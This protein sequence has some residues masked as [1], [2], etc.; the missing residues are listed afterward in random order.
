VKATRGVSVITRAGVVVGVVLL[1]ALGGAAVSGAKPHRQV[2]DSR[3]AA[4]GNEYKSF[5]ALPSLPHWVW[6]IPYGCVFIRDRAPTPDCQH[7]DVRNGCAPPP[8]V[9]VRY[10]GHTYV[11]HLTLKGVP[12]KAKGLWTAGG[13]RRFIVAHDGVPPK[14]RQRLFI[15]FSGTEFDGLL[16]SG[17]SKGLPDLGPEL[18]WRIA[19]NIDKKNGLCCPHVDPGDPDQ[20]PP[21]DVTPQ[22]LVVAKG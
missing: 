4:V 19:Y 21:F 6:T 9:D 11:F 16:Q 18:R 10:R 22:R 8:D 17:P 12:T 1:L 14:S 20:K 5:A 2:A 3:C 13:T 15:E 7:T